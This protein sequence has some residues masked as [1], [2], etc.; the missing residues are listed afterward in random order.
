LLAGIADRV[1]DQVVKFFDVFGCQVGQIS[2]L[3]V[4]PDLLC[5]IKVRRIGWQPFNT[6]SLGVNFQVSP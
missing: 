1:T 6:D 5:R 4:V 2:I 3:A